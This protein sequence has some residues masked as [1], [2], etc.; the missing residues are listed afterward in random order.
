MFWSENKDCVVKQRMS[1]SVTEV[2]EKT[3]RGWGGDSLEERDSTSK[4]EGS[5]ISF[6]LE[7][8]LLYFKA[9]PG[10]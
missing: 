1:S 5:Q 3:E 8:T 10:T 4:W 6:P 2:F 9:C 7:S